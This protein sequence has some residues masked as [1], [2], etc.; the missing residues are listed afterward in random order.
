MGRDEGV[1]FRVVGGADDQVHAIQ[2][3]RKEGPVMA[4]DLE[5]LQSFKKGRHIG[6]G[7][8]P[9]AAAGGPQHL[10]FSSR[11]VPAAHYQDALPAQIQKQGQ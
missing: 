7:Y 2:V 11:D 9:E 8:H 6:Q 5:A 3:I 1:G 10:H 4:L